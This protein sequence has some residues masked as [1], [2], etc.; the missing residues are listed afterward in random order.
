VVSYYRK[1]VTDSGHIPKGMLLHGR[2][3]GEDR[4]QITGE[5]SGDVYNAPT[6]TKHLDL[7]VVEGNVFVLK[8]GAMPSDEPDSI[9]CGDTVVITSE[10]A[11]RLGKREF[12]F[13]ELI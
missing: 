5:V 8:P 3:I 13:P 11:R 12:C 9:R 4:P 1:L 6:Y 10:G 2:G 7:P